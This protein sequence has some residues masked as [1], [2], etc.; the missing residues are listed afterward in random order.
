MIQVI[1]IGNRD[2]GDDAAGLEVAARLRAASPAGVEIIDLEGD[3]IRLLDVWATDATVIL[4]DATCSGAVPGTVTRF[5]ASCPLSHQF[6]HRGSHTFGLADVIEL[7]RALDRLPRHLSGY[8]IEG[9]SFAIGAPFSAEVATA[10]TDVTACLLKAFTPSGQDV[11][12]AGQTRPLPCAAREKRAFP[13]PSTCASS[14][15]SSR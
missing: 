11:S 13:S 5:D 15:L 3:Q 4:I 2:R 8:G 14:T 10:V 12:G 1:G 6:S 9:A 7:A